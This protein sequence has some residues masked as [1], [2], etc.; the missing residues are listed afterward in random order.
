MNTFNDGAALVMCN[1]EICI[2][3]Q[4]EIETFQQ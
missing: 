3:D 2:P 4:S 1:E